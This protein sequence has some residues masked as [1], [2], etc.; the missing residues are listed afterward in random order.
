MNKF[1]MLLT[2]MTS[3]AV[4]AGNFP[5][6]SIGQLTGSVATPPDAT[7][8]LSVPGL[9]QALLQAGAVPNADGTVTVTLNGVSVTVSPDG[10]VKQQ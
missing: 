7:A 4:M 2:L 1:L 9:F 10:T 6:P 3:S 5:L 8:V